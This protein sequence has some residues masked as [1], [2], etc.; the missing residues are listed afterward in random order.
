MNSV[1]FV[2][3]VPILDDWQALSLLIPRLASSAHSLADGA[4]LLIVDD[5][6]DKTAEEAG[7]PTRF[8]GLSWIRVLRLRRNLGHQRA[9]AVGL[10]YVDAHIPCDNVVVMDGD[11]ED[12][13]EDIHSLLSRAAAEHGR[14]IVFAERRRRVEGLGFRLGYA[15]YRVLHRLLT[16]R[17]VK[18]GNFSVVPRRLLESLTVVS[19]LWIHY[20]ASVVRSRQPW[21]AVPV[22]RGRRLDG[23]SRMNLVALVVHGLSAISVYADV[24]FTRLVVAAAALVGLALIGLVLVMAVRMATTLAIPGWATYVAGMLVL[25]LLQAAFFVASLVFLVLG[26]R[27]QAVVVPRRDYV[28]YVAGVTELSTSANGL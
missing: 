2:I 21:C 14:R 25:V 7:V 27:Q 9:I 6:S 10:C 5:G 26:A 3:L 22:A 1:S 24:V 19:E 23:R 17:G 15:A 11:G 13:P 8:D 16:G 28:H 18:I 4:G 20:A 12:R